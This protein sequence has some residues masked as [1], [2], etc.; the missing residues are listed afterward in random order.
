MMFIHQ[1]VLK[2]VKQNHWTMQYRSQSATFI[3]RSN[4]G[5]YWFILPK[6][7]VHA[8]NSLQ[9]VRRNHWTVKCGSCWP[10]LHDPQVHVTRLSNVL[11]TICIRC[12]H[13]RK[14][15]KTFKRCLRFWPPAPPR[16]M[17]LGSGVKERKLTLQGT[18]V[19]IGMLS[20]EWLVRY[21][22]LE[23]L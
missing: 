2:D 10:S 23:K 6:Y 16:G 5:S 22:P 1:I 11:Q 4:I 13:K 12:F 3:L 14:S 19:Q 21:T 15:R 8:S 17:D 9:H 20:D 18:Y 7:D